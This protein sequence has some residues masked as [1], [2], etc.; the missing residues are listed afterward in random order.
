MESRAGVP[1]RHTGSESERHLRRWPHRQA[2]DLVVL[3]AL[4]D[5][6][7]RSFDRF[8]AGQHRRACR[9]RAFG[10]PVGPDVLDQLAGAQSARFGPGGAGGGRRRH[11]IEHVDE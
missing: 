9:E 6:A 11:R 3:A 5:D 8:L 7:A 1:R 2:E 4:D 10:T